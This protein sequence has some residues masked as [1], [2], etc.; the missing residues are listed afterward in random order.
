M[1]S[2]RRT[3][4]SK[5]KHKH[6]SIISLRRG[7]PMRGFLA[8][9]LFKF[10]YAQGRGPSN[11]TT[12]KDTR[13]VLVPQVKPNPEVDEKV[14]RLCEIENELTAWQELLKRIRSTS[15]LK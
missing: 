13:R 12:E 10:P 15:P 4:P 11:I 14:H 2:T 3:M 6:C 9:L 5:E 1:R 7:K 8:S